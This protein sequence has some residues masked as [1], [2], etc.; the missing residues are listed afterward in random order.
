[1]AKSS[2]PFS[3]EIPSW[4][5]TAYSNL[6]ELDLSTNNLSSIVPSGFGACSFLGLLFF[7]LVVVGVLGGVGW[8]V[9]LILGRWVGSGGWAWMK[10][11][12]TEDIDSA[13]SVDFCS[14][15]LDRKKS[16]RR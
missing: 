13:F 8:W 4:L 1:M 2:N 11:D 10:S 9:G 16:D 6:I 15:L 12:W 3:G 7:F 14:G 5:S